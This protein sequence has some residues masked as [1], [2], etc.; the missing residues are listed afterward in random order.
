[1]NKIE[2]FPASFTDNPYDYFATATDNNT[3]LFAPGIGPCI[4]G[5]FYRQGHVGLGHFDPMMDPVVRDISRVVRPRM[6]EQGTGDIGCMLYTGQ[7]FAVRPE[8]QRQ[9]G[10]ERYYDYV[11]RIEELGFIFGHD[12]S[13]T[14]I[15]ANEGPVLLIKKIQA[16]LTGDNLDTVHVLMNYVDLD[17]KRKVKEASEEFEIDTRTHQT[18]VIQAFTGRRMF[19]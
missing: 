14:Y 19:R 2:I 10:I 11:R 7:S 9:Q 12:G 18:K 5:L 13:R 17:S 8:F 6:Q 3:A 15:L 4:G 16:R 1:M